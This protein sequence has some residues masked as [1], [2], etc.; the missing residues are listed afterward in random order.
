MTAFIVESYKNLLPDDSATTGNALRALSL[1]MTSF[2]LTDRYANST[3]VVA[4][5]SSPPPST[6]AIR[7]N[8][9]W[10]ASLICSLVAASL[11][12]LV[13]QWLREYLAVDYLSPQARV[14][15]RQFR[16]EGLKQ[17]RVFEI[18]A[19][20]PL[21]LQI[22][23][24]L[25][26]LGICFFTL[27]INTTVGWTSTPLVLAWV[28]FFTF[29]VL[30]PAISAHCPF[31][32]TFLK[33]ALK[34]IRRL[35]LHHVSPLSE[36]SIGAPPDTSGR[37][38]TSSTLVGQRSAKD[39]APKEEEDAVTNH[40]QDLG[41]LLAFDEIN[42]DD[43]LLGTVVR[44]ILTPTR[45]NGAEVLAFVQ[46]I[47]AHRL[48]RDVSS[49]LPSRY[50]Q[51][52][53]PRARLALVDILSDALCYEVQERLFGSTSAATTDTSEDKTLSGWMNT[54]LVMIVG[55]AGDSMQRSEAAAMAFCLMFDP[56]TFRDVAGKAR[57]TTDDFLT[58]IGV[59]QDRLR[60]SRGS[61]I[62]DFLRDTSQWYTQQSGESKEE[63]V[64]SME[65]TL[66]GVL[67]ASEPKLP[68]ECLSAVLGLLV[69]T[70][71]AQRKGNW[72]EW[73]TEAL[74]CLIDATDPTEGHYCVS[75]MDKIS[76]LV[77]LMMTD[78]YNA[79]KVLA[80]LTRVQPFDWHS[81]YWML[82]LVIGRKLSNAQGGIPAML[83]NLE[84]AMVMR[85]Y[86]GMFNS[87]CVCTMFCNMASYFF[88]PEDI[89][90]HRGQWRALF[91]ALSRTITPNLDLTLSDRLAVAHCLER[92]DVFDSV[93][94]TAPGV[95]QDGAKVDPIVPDD[96]I[97]T[98][99]DIAEDASRR[100]ENLRRVSKLR[101][102]RLSE[103]TPRAG[104]AMATE[105]VESQLVAEDVFV[106]AEEVP[107]VD[108]SLPL[109]PSLGIRNLPQ[110]WNQP[111]SSRRGPPEPSMSYYNPTVAS[112]A[113]NPQNRSRTSDPSTVFP[114]IQDWL[115]S[116][117]IDSTRNHQGQ[118]KYSPYARRLIENGI[119]D[120]GDLVRLRKIEAEQ[121]V[122]K[123][124]KLG[125]MVY[126]IASRLL[127]F[128]QADASELIRA[129]QAQQNSQ[130]A[131]EG[132]HVG[133][134][135]FSL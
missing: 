101:A 96:L 52:L 88:A 3:R 53:A 70:L 42:S 97:E 130:A 44:T 132:P 107:A 76:D 79:G 37:T 127:E 74:D 31:K 22:A 1:Q 7:V 108:F 82:G 49:L 58:L 51:F 67:K 103:Q 2:V 39:K 83:R 11:G 109:S 45:R 129:R 126:G 100:V 119:Y 72:E 9:L 65:T 92:I 85:T 55:L 4:A 56:L 63:S 123:L 84:D 15:I 99:S 34:S 116:L 134:N 60:N 128:A 93:E 12:M 135:A 91:T 21:L 86:P 23:L 19:L 38:S 46:K 54:A 13:K 28:T 117:D 118:L 27:S 112:H 105:S 77:V 14:R 17:W 94:A 20:L 48:Q 75:A 71:R 133:S 62:M 30:A 80:S 110:D 95:R 41:I 120:L 26:F 89:Q 73:Q 87:V 50:S 64:L 121:A 81:R 124:Q 61:S 18:A 106:D 43:E 35:L 69:D 66:S 98:L 102:Q 6:T 25:F 10:F 122:A 29:T 24:G 47:V 33:F 16:W 104:Y 8:S 115:L 59:A 57:L 90:T 68:D 111:S 114:S 113:S 5:T 78:G 32:T 40:T 131:N 36:R 125:G